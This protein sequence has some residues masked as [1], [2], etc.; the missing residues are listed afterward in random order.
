MF[1]RLQYLN[2]E[3]SHDV[4]YSQFVNSATI[5]IVKNTLGEKIKQSKDEHFNDIPLI[6]WDKINLAGI[7]YSFDKGAFKQCNNVTYRESDRH[8]FI[9]SKSDNVCILK[10][11]ARIIKNNS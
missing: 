8:L 7:L 1:N 6:L 11:A 9:W 2:G 4:Y 10:A 5:A 3:C